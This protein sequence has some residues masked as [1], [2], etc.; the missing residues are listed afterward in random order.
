[1]SQLQKMLNLQN[2]LQERLG[3][4]IDE[5]DAEERTRFIKEFSIHINQEINEMLYELPYF[6]PWKD[7]SNMDSVAIADAFNKARYEFIDAWHFILNIALALGFSEDELYDS[8]YAK[9]IE[10]HKR[11]DEGYTHDKLYR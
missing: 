11:Q 8:Y 5:M 4:N 6:K 3:Y 10:N 9:N 1:M 2:S 7:Y